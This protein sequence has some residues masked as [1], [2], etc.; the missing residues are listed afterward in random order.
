MRF[1][2]P[3]R[4]EE[5]ERPPEP[6]R[7]EPPTRY[8]RLLALQR[9]AGNRAVARFLDVQQIDFNPLSGN[10]H[11]SH[12]DVPMFLQTISGSN[13]HGACNQAEK[14]RLQNVD[15]ANLAALDVPRLATAI[16]QH[17]AN[18]R[19]P[20]ID[21]L[22]PHRS[23]LEGAL[24]V[25][26]PREVSDKEENVFKR[27]L[28]RASHK[29]RSKGTPNQI[30]LAALTQFEPD[31]ANGVNFIHGLVTARNQEL[32]TLNTFTAEPSFSSA[33]HAVNGL[34]ARSAHMNM[35]GWLAQHNAPATLDVAANAWAQQM[36]LTGGGMYRSEIVRVFGG[37]PAGVTAAM[38]ESSDLDLQVKRRY[39]REVMFTTL[40]TPRQRATHA[41]REY[42]NG[43]LAGCPFIEFTATNAGGLSRY[44]WD[45]VND[46]WYVNVHYNW[47]LGYNPFF[48]VNGLGPSI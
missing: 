32:G 11:T 6:R 17:V 34:P 3:R 36:A 29:S 41:W 8:D 46:R 25:A 48:L 12:L 45:Y 1:A 9:A 37:A 10:F 15:G 39:Y 28:D 5:R 44:V 43:T 40:A 38:I 35:A 30:A 13:F 33:D 47:V 4:P 14:G 19:Q 42:A 27:V 22:T 24:V 18:N 26:A 21:A 23:N 20:R 7:P 31:M 16:I 2:D